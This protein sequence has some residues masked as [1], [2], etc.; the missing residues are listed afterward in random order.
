M[1]ELGGRP[2]AAVSLTDGRAIAD[3]FVR[4]AEILALVSLRAEQ[5]GVGT[6]GRRRW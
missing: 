1:G 6:P 3:P 2:V 4:S 5:L